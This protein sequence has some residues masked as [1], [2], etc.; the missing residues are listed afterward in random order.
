[1]TATPEELLYTESHEWIR[2]NGDGTVTMGITDHAQSQLGDVVF[3]EL[4]EDGQAFEKGDDLAVVESVKSASDIY[5][6][7]G[8]TVE[9]VNEEL[10]DAPETVN[11]DCYGGGWMVKLKVDNPDELQGLLTAEQYAAHIASES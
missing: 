6:P 2:D 3:V 5:S 8:G 7:V 11:E 10:E 1:M 4:P 9:G